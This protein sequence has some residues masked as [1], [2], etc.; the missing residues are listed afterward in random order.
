MRLSVKSAAYPLV[1]GGIGADGGLDDSLRRVLA[2]EEAYINSTKNAQ[3]NG[4]RQP[5]GSASGWLDVLSP[6]G[7]RAAVGI[8]PP[9]ALTQPLF[10]R[11]LVD[12]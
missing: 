2:M 12:A 6:V 9:L 8:D 10:G 4:Y 1:D 11:P 7:V 5:L 3:D